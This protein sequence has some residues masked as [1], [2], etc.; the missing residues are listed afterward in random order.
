MRSLVKLHA[1]LTQER[2]GY[3][4]CDLKESSHKIVVVECSN[5]NR[6]LEREFRNAFKT[7][8]CP[9]VE[10]NNKRCFKCQEWK[11]LSLFNKCPKLSG[12][13]AKLCRECYN[14]YDSV[15]RCE[16]NKRNRRKRSFS[17]DFPNYI[18][19]RAYSIKNQCK[20]KNI[21]YDLDVDYLLEL[22]SNQEGK[23][24]YSNIEM[25]SEGHVNGFQ[26]WFSPSLD[27]KNP[28]DGYTKGNVVWTCFC[29][30]SFKQA[31]T[32]EQFK[33]LLKNIQWNL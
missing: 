12:G 28:S 26:S 30:N 29:V 16:I 27:R 23:C 19:Y 9:I 25:K 32:D 7:H 1:E 14:K 31:M 4:P 6:I 15:K 22:W 2:Y 11:D 20:S 5:C 17:E 24:Y 3:K 13:V 21:M 33:K 8:S 18:K 10:G